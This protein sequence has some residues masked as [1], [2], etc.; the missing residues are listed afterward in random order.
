MQQPCKLLI[1][2]LSLWLDECSCRHRHH[3]YNY[4]EEKVKRETGL[5]EAAK[6]I[7]TW[8]DRKPTRTSSKTASGDKDT[9]VYVAA[10]VSNT[11]S[12]YTVTVYRPTGMRNCALGL[13]TARTSPLKNHQEVMAVVKV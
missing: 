13:S 12:S 11:T 4:F 1:V 6:Q 9:E 3:D 7:A 8:Y 10:A 5:T 2:N